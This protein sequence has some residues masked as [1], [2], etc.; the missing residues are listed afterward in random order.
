MA[1][2]ESEFLP[3]E[4]GQ[5]V[6]SPLQL[7]I[8]LLAFYS[9]APWHPRTQTHEEGLTYLLHN[10]LIQ[11]DGALDAVGEYLFSTTEKGDHHVQTILSLPFPRAQWVTPMPTPID[12]G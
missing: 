10:G 8:L 11:L 4:R 12:H 1:I 3:A 7:E 9:R 5:H 2:A 6:L